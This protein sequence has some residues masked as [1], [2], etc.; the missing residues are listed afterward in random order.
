VAVDNRQDYG[1][2]SAATLR[3]DTYEEN[4]RALGFLKA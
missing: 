1:R 2:A 3:V 4:T